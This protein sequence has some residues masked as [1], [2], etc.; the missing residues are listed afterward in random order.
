MSGIKPCPFGCPP[1]I[2]E[3]Q[4]SPHLVMNYVGPSPLQ[5][6]SGPYTKSHRVVCAVCGCRGPEFVE[7]N[8]ASEDAE[9]QAIA[10]WNRREP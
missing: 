10:K 5:Q 2:D 8:W 1:E 9:A 4:K 7:S 3:D 6:Y